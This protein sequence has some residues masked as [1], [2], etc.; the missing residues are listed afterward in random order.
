VKALTLTQPW[1]TLVALGAKR[2]ETRS[3]YTGPDP[4][5]HG[6]QALN[7]PL[8]IHAAKGFPPEAQALVAKGWFASVL[9]AAFP[10]A[11]R[12]E[13]VI[14]QLPRGAVVATVVLLH[15]VTVE[16]LEG[17]P[18]ILTPQER[19]FGNYQPGRYAWRLWN[20]EALPE[21]IPA[22]GSLGLWEWD[23]PAG[24]AERLTEVTA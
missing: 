24:V 17:A 7:L 20:V 19:A 16:H 8:A 18:H 12:P 1:A 23:A 13:D 2:I 15:C 10:D 9:R 4:R 6:A 11:A 22:R 5:G 3:W 14:D 21:P